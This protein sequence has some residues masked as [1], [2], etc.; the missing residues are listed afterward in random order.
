MKNTILPFIGILAFSLIFSC[1]TPVKEHK[2][3]NNTAGEKPRIVN[4]INWGFDRELQS[5]VP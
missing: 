4:I 2:E 3:A 1:T 5:V